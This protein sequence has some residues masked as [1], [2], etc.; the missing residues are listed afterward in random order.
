LNFWFSNDRIS[1]LVVGECN[2]RYLRVQPFKVKGSTLVE[3]V[4]QQERPALFGISGKSNRDVGRRKHWGKNEFNSSFPTALLCYMNSRNINPIYLKMGGDH[5]IFQDT[6]SVTELFGIEPTSPNAYFSFE[7]A[8]VP[9]QRFVQGQLPRADLVTMDKST[10]ETPWKRGLEIK[11]TALPDNTTYNLSEDKYSC[12]MVFRPTAIVHLALS[13]SDLFSNRRTELLSLLAPICSTTFNW[14]DKN[15][16]FQRNESFIQI[17]RSVLLLGVDNQEPFVIQPIWKTKGK[18]AVLA[19]NCLDVFVWAN[20]A[21]AKMLIDQV[22]EGASRRAMSR[23]IRCIIWLV[24]MLY[25]F[26]HTGLINPSLITSEMAYEL[27]TDKAFSVNGLSSWR[28]LHGPALTE[29]RINKNDI[30]NI[31]LGGGQNLLSPERRFD[32]IIVNTPELFD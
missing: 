11:L 25:D 1:L 19:D 2:K 27:Q 17:L 3:N 32:A 10:P 6:I 29:P 18:K 28:Y 8:Y 7:D 22:E 16:M 30:R 9:L 15:E 5:E 4:A 21:F 14:R 31:I 24:R 13:I 23:T 26:G 12:E 20:L